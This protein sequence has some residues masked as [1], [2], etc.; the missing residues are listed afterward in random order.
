MQMLIQLQRATEI[1]TERLFQHDTVAEQLAAE[2]SGIQFTHHMRK[3]RGR[4]SQIKDNIRAQALARLAQ[5]K[6]QIDVVRRLV[7]HHSHI[8]KATQ[9]FLELDLI[10]ILTQLLRQLL[11]HKRLPLGSVPITPRDADKCQTLRQPAVTIKVIQCRQK[12]VDREITRRTKDHKLTGRYH[13]A[14]SLPSP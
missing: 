14:G 8:A 12:L 3:V 2:S 1:M 4:N 7:I 5:F 6:F 11:A 13:F 10:K 9:E